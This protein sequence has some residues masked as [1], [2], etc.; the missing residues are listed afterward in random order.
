MW[1]MR[2]RRT[3]ERVTSTPQRSQ[4]TLAAVALPVLGRPEDALAEQTVAFWLEG[5]VVDG[6]RFFYFTA[7]PTADDFRAGKI[8]RNMIDFIDV[9]Q[10]RRSLLNRT[11]SVV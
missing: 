2:S 9:S 8:Y 4:M 11:V 5:S 6:F 7:A 1:P 3:F 10:K